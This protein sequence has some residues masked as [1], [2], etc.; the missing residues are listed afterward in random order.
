MSQ[1]ITVTK[2][3]AQKCTYAQLA[4]VL[5]G[6]QLCLVQESFDDVSVCYGCGRYSTA[7]PEECQGVLEESHGARMLI[8]S[9]ISGEINSPNY[10]PLSLVKYANRKETAHNY[11]LM[12]GG[13]PDDYEC[14]H[15]AFSGNLSMTVRPVDLKDAQN[16]VPQGKPFD[17][18][19]VEAMVG[20]L[21]DEEINAVEIVLATGWSFVGAQAGIPDQ[22]YSRLLFRK[23]YERKYIHPDGTERIVHKG[24]SGKIEL[25]S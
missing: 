4:G 6:E 10:R 8:A 5:H 12:V 24:M 11:A 14:M 19:L 2:G 7:I 23:G 16:A 1:S 9:I 21:S 25:D 17:R 3:T 22:S 15:L 20:K 13:D 18:D